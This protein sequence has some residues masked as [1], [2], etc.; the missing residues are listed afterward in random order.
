[1]TQLRQGGEA[2]HEDA[3]KIRKKRT[4]TP[5][6]RGRLLDNSL[7]QIGNNCSGGGGSPASTGASFSPGFVTSSCI[8]PRLRMRL[9]ESRSIV[10]TSD[11]DLGCDFPMQG[12]NLCFDSRLEGV[13]ADHE[14]IDEELPGKRI[15][16]L[17]LAAWRTPVRSRCSF[18][19]VSTGRES[20]VAGFGVCELFLTYYHSCFHSLPDL[21]NSNMSNNSPRLSTN[22][23][24]K[25]RERGS[26]KIH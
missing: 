12:V 19:S 2:G 3:S 24:Q 26:S 23:E 17:K 9:D 13:P 5:P 14:V 8:Q 7:F 15:C 20:L 18:V 21:G 16:E 4:S 11:G 6:A 1:M 25:R 10:R 22:E